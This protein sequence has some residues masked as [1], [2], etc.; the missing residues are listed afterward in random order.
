MLQIV[1][2]AAFG[3]TAYAPPFDSIADAIY[4]SGTTITTTGL[5]KF[6]LHSVI[7]QLLRVY[8]PMSGFVLLAVALG[9]YVADRRSP[10][11]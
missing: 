9:A 1:S 10:I 2:A 8:E 7:P 3:A 11:L 5:A 6:E 4:F